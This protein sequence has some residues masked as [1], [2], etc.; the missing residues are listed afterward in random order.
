MEEVEIFIMNQ[1]KPFYA[2]G[3]VTLKK[4]YWLKDLQGLIFQKHR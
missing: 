3:K 4:S 1:L 2:S